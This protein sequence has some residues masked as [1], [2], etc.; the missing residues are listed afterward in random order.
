MAP[1][2]NKRSK[3][4]D[5]PDP[6]DEDDDERLPYFVPEEGIDI[7]PLALYARGILDREARVRTGTHPQVRSHGPMHCDCISLFSTLT[8]FA[9]R[10]EQKG[11]WIMSGIAV[12]RVG[13]AFTGPDSSHRLTTM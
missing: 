7:E 2:K 10:P 12:T 13:P 3:R 4:K 5:S 11:F 8:R 6:E 9:Q 1:P